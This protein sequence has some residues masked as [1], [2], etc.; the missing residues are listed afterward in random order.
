[1]PALLQLDKAVL[2]GREGVLRE[3]REQSAEGARPRRA[4]AHR[5]LARGEREPENGQLV[6]ER[7]RRPAEHG[8]VRLGG[9][10]RRA[11]REL[12]VALADRHRLVAQPSE[13]PPSAGPEGRL[14]EQRSRVGLQRDGGCDAEAVHLPDAQSLCGAGARS[15]E[16][17]HLW[18][19][20]PEGLQTRT[21]HSAAAHQPDL[22]QSFA[23]DADLFRMRGGG[24][25]SARVQVV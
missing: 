1:V 11:R 13:P 25:S 20:R 10:R 8:P 23:H 5:A 24:S 21:A 16:R 18:N 15:A 4:R 3:C 14:R 22:L 9:I 7:R 17:L 19:T 12:Q 2:R 6:L